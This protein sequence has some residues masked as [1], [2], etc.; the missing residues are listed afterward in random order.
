MSLLLLSP[1]DLPMASLHRA[2]L[3]KY[4]GFSLASQHPFQNP[5]L[6]GEAIT[7]FKSTQDTPL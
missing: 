3:A 4:H 6:S 5:E 1:E 2:S 7:W